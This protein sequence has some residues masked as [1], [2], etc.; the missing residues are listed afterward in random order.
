MWVHCKAHS[1][2]LHRG[3]EFGLA[4]AMEKG[5]EHLWLFVKTGVHTSYMRINRVPERLLKVQERIF[6]EYF[7]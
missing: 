6:K 4:Q 3:R 2:I 5:L 1:A 7:K